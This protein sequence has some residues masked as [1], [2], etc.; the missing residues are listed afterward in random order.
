MK[1]LLTK[2]A[3]L[4]LWRLLRADEPLRLD[5]TLTRTDGVDRDAMFEAEMRAWYLRLLDTAPAEFLAPVN[6]AVKAEVSE[7]ASTGLTIVT[8]PEESRRVLALKFDGWHSP[9]VPNSSVD[10]VT[11]YAANPFCRTPMAARHSARTILVANASGVLSELS[12]AV[13]LGQD[14]YC[15]DERALELIMKPD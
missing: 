11:A 8:A 14:A 4:D 6:T 5:C 9:V 1:K 13:D 10:D 2:A 12:C 3:M 15:F 7:S